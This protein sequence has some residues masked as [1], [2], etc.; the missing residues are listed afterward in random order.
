MAVNQTREAVKSA[1]SDPKWAEKVDSMSDDK[2]VA[3]FMRL[4]AQGKLKV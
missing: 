3:I 1:Y 4:K 2:V